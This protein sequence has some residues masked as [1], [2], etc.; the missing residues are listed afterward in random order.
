V[1]YL[2]VDNGRKRV[3]LALSDPGETFSSP[4]R[5]LQ[6]R[7]TE[8]VVAE[9]AEVCR[10]EDVGAVVVGLPLNMDG[11]R[12]QMAQEAQRLG[13][14]I[15]EATGLPVELWDE[16]LSSV[17]AERHLIDADMSRARRK[18]TIDKVAAQI[19]LQSYLDARA[20]RRE[21]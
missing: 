1:R 6:R 5:V 16:R 13:D 4:L 3:G 11:T 15:A 17:S 7:S 21:E 12:G 19:I 10:A 2:G 20:H 18:R 8:Q 9:V 14:L